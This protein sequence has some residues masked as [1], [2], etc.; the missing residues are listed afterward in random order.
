VLVKKGRVVNRLIIFIV[1]YGW[2]VG[3]LGYRATV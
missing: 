1:Q 3:H 2:L